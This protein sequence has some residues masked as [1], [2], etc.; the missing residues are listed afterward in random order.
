LGIGVFVKH[1][2]VIVSQMN[3]VLVI[4]GTYHRSVIVPQ[5]IKSYAVEMDSRAEG[6][7]IESLVATNK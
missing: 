2:R 3:F 7:E 6:H 1:N 5:T 4:L